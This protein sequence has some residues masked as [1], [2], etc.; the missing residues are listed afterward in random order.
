MTAAAQPGAVAAGHSWPRIRALVGGRSFRAKRRGVDGGR[1]H[2]DAQ[3]EG[4]GRDGPT[5]R[6]GAGRA[7]RQA[8]TILG[9]IGG[10]PVRVSASL[11]GRR[12][13]LDMLYVHPTGAGHGRRHHA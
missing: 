2:S 6:G 5:T 9:M 3:R 8:L 4:L 12:T 10:S 7:A 13:K 1:L 11:K